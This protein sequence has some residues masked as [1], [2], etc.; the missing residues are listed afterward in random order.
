MPLQT[1]SDGKKREHKGLKSNSMTSVALLSTQVE[2]GLF[3]PSRDTN[4][5]MPSG[6]YVIPLP[7][8]HDKK[9]QNK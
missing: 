9:L 5:F 3:L 4:K 1:K 8:S 7:H 6:L 2:A